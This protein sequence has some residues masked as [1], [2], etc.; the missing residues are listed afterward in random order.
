MNV[1]ICNVDG[2]SVI[3]DGNKL[4]I[5]GKDYDYPGKSKGQTTSIVGDKIYIGS[6]RFKNG[7]FKRSFKAIWENY[8][9]F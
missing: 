1:T 8:I 4:I 6:Y 2:P 3:S 5:N 7:K 9:W